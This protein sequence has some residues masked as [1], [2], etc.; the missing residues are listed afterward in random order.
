MTAK[1]EIKIKL[2]HISLTKLLWYMGMLVRRGASTSVAGRGSRMA[3]SIK[4]GNHAR[5]WRG[6]E[7]RQ[8]WGKGLRARHFSRE[9]RI[10]LKPSPKRIQTKCTE[11]GHISSFLGHT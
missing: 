11:V 2:V 7:G 10:K 8:G 1:C 6:K 5:K 4:S 3:F 9:Q